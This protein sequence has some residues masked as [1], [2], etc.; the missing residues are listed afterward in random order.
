MLICFRPA[1]D[2]AM[3]NLRLS[4]PVAE[5]IVNEIRKAEKP[6]LQDESQ[7]N[8]TLNRQQRKNVNMI[9]PISNKSK[10]YLLE[11]IFSCHF[12]C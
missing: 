1:L 2:P 10:N 4:F 7:I 12:Q 5:H 8:F 11:L 3:K 9:Q 6:G